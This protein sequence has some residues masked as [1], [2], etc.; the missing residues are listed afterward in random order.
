MRAFELKQTASR[1]SQEAVGSSGLKRELDTVDDVAE[2]VADGRAEERQDH[3]NDDRD[4]NQDQGIFYEALALIIFE[5]KHGE[6]P[7]V[8]RG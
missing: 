5:G 6:C 4:Q 3:D 1:S 8:K 7:F 2:D